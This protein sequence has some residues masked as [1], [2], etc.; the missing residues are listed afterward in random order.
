MTRHWR[1]FPV[2]VLAAVALTAGCTDT[3]QDTIGEKIKFAGRDD[4][5]ASVMGRFNSASGD[6]EEAVQA[7]GTSPT[8]TLAALEL[9]DD[10]LRELRR[11]YDKWSILVDDVIDASIEGTPRAELRAWRDAA[12]DWI[13]A[14]EAI[15][16]AMVACDHALACLERAQSR[17]T[18]VVVAATTRAQEAKRRF[19][20]AVPDE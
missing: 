15:T 18:P 17:H 5:D 16:A 3:P 1:P 8:A 14:Q 6:F 7:F 9:A 4:G 2:A 19:V 13:E 12:G 11:A 10:R 20:A